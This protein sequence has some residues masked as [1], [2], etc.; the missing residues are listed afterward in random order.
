MSLKNASPQDYAS[1]E[2]WFNDNEVDLYAEYM[3]T[4]SSYEIDF[5]DWCENRYNMEM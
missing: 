2:D 1:Y 5:D 3:E 4:G